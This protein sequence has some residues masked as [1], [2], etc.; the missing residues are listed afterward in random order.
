MLTSLIKICSEKSHGTKFRG[1][2]EYHPYFRLTKE[3]NSHELTKKASYDETNWSVEIQ[4]HSFAHIK[5]LFAGIDSKLKST[6]FLAFH[7]SH[8]P[9]RGTH[10]HNLSTT[11]KPKNGVSRTADMPKHQFCG[12]KSKER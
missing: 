1:R 2:K 4:H 10:N 12:A 6:P 11:M 9:T 5:L 7:N 8:K 3:S